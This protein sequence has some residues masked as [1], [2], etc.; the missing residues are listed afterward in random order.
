M[1]R[2]LKG[3]GSSA[4]EARMTSRPRSGLPGTR[5][6]YLTALAAALLLGL[7]LVWEA[8]SLIRE[9]QR[10]VEDWRHRLVTLADARGEAIDSWMSDQRIAA[11]IESSRRAVRGFLRGTEPSDDAASVLRSDLGKSRFRRISLLDVDGTVRLVMPPTVAPAETYALTLGG[12]HGKGVDP[13]AIA[14]HADDPGGPTLHVAAPI[15]DGPG[16]RLGILLLDLD[17]A[18]DL[19]RL[20]AYDAKAGASAENLLVAW[21]SGAVRY[22]SPRRFSSSQAPLRPF[23]RGDLHL[24]AVD[25]LSKPAAFGRFVD[26][27]GVAVLAATHQVAGVPWGLVVKIDEQ[28]AL[29]QWRWSASES[30]GRSVGLLLTLLA[31]GW[32]FF[33]Q[34]RLRDLERNAT[35][36]ARYRLLLERAHDAVFIASADNGR[37]LEANLAAE[38]LYG[39]SHEQFMQLTLIDLRSSSSQIHLHELLGGADVSESAAAETKH[40]RRD[41]TELHVEVSGGRLIGDGEPLVLAIVRDI[42]RRKEA[43]ARLDQINRLLRVGIEL[44]TL[45]LCGD[46]RGLLLDQ[47]CARLVQDVRFRMACIAIVDPASG[48]LF[49][50][51]H[52]GIAAGAGTLPDLHAREAFATRR[53]VV[54]QEDSALPAGCR[55]GV[56]VPLSSGAQTIG[57]LAVFESEPSRLDGAV[58]SVLEQLVADLGIRLDLGAKTAELALNEASYRLLFESNPMA[59]WVY[60]R[61]TLAILGANQAAVEQ[62]G[63]PRAELLRRTLVDFHP[64]KD[65]Q[66]V[67]GENASAPGL[68]RRPGVFRHRRA[69]GQIIEVDV[70]T[71]DIDF[72]GRPGRLTLLENV[73]ERRVMERAL[74]ESEERFRSAFEDATVG[75]AIIAPQSTVVL[76]ANQAACD[77]LG[78]PMSEI[79]GMPFS[80]FTHVDDLGA[81]EQ[82]I[83]AMLAGEE[84][85]PLAHRRLL[86]RDGH[87]VWTELSAR[88]L[89][90]EEHKPLYFLVVVQDITA[91]LASERALL[92]SEERFRSA[93][94]DSPIAMALTAP[95]GRLQ[96]ANAA[97]GA[98][99]GRGSEALSERNYRELT[100]PD[101]RELSTRAASAMIAG[102]GDSMRFEKRYLK[103]DGSIVRADVSVRLL[104]DSA[105][106]PLY[107]V[108][109]AQ[110]ITARRAAEEALRDSQ[111]KLQVAIESTQ[112]GLWD[113]HVASGAVQY[114]KEW[115]SL[116]GYSANEV[117]DSF[118]EF[119]RLT[120]PED[121][122]A[123]RAALA[124]FMK[125]PVG[126]LAEE[127]RMRHRDGSIRWILSRGAAIELGEDGRP[128]R[129]VG[130]HID[131]TERRRSE[132]DLHD[133]L[134]RFELASRATNDVVWEWDLRANTIWWSEGL[135]SVLGY[136][137]GEISTSADWWRER[138]HPDELERVSEGANAAVREGRSRW[139]ET[140]RFRNAAGDYLEVD[141]RGFLVLDD[142]GTA[143]RMVG[144]MTDVSARRRAEREV[145]RANE[146]LEQRVRERTFELETANRE[147]ESFS[148]SV[149]HDLRAPLRA[150]SGFSR[151]LGEQHAGQLDA[152]GL[153][154]LGVVR[155]NTQRMGQLVDDLLAF[156]RVSRQELRRVQ[157]DMTALAEAAWR[158]AT[159]DDHGPP[160][161]LRLEPLPAIRGDLSLLRQVWLN[162]LTNALK[163]SVPRPRRLVEVSGRIEDGTAV[164]T[165][166]DNGVGFDMAYADKLF[167]VFQRLHGRDEF[168]GTG[169]GLALVQ[170]IVQ[171]H[172]GSVSGVGSPGVGATFS[173]RLRLDVDESGTGPRDGVPAL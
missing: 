6:T 79:T 82:R 15:D 20:L 70:V 133:A 63:Y 5:Q 131:I 147:L 19:Y 21:D 50:A 170:R 83:A 173:F 69:D 143:R 89:H 17:P 52:A 137:N 106:Q 149:S 86:H 121:R 167:G 30:L 105:R 112:I 120:L 4:A 130:V 10:E 9:R 59:M 47:V 43:E 93:F 157:V 135:A 14:L 119:E 49:C 117:G 101:D 18:R 150:I 148:Y 118:D 142:S 154:L 62:Y 109:I 25:A 158:E 90:D 55:A 98:M 87:V 44:N 75:M 146:M 104:R 12:A 123:N 3:R 85:A 39:Y 26:Y 46:E 66:F 11:H 54:A 40:R 88:L 139:H 84:F 91:R 164:Y 95:S 140:Y 163:F 72:A 73:T 172:G 155:N 32:M 100:H 28:E 128:R 53:V 35:R 134:E 51:A 37:I 107:F 160:V 145:Q 1:R 116:L 7:M 58:R 65:Q 153:R 78:Y 16:R 136:P 138:V 141:D 38:R 13:F 77:L 29:S 60:D 94:D 152:E 61:E 144:A 41:G 110:D 34:V 102:K 169:V 97:F 166:N 111:A 76:R 159:A 96:R 56:Y 8:S 127:F 45:A 132:E 99:L 92:E 126:Y 171:R 129:L 168:E 161:E 125:H 24:A 2:D 114:S 36:D 74:R 27:R 151:I 81:M 165:V 67:R 48:D 80:R 115:K 42:S 162:L 108:T 103:S 122:A 124:A 22:L 71:H 33:H 113:W 64:E 31:L 57:V 23:T 156:S 68:L